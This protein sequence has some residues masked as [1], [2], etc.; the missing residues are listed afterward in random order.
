MGFNS[1]RKLLITVFRLANT[2]YKDTE[3]VIHYYQ[4]SW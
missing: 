2:T 4:M 3:I 1:D